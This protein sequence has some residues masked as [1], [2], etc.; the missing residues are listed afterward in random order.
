MN[1]SVIRSG[2]ALAAM[3]G[4][5]LA[6]CDSVKDV[7]EEP[8]TAIP[9]TTAVLQGTITGLGSARPVALS[10][11]GQPNC[12]AADPVDASVRVP[13]QCR[14]YGVA[15][16][17]QVSF[18]FGSL[19]VGTPY[20]ISVQAQP[21][22]KVCQV[23]NASGTVGSG[24]APSVVCEDSDAVARHD[25]TVNI[26]PALQTLPNLKVRVTTEEDI[27]EADAT[28]LASVSFPDVLIDTGISLPQFA[29]KVAATT[30]TTVNGETITNYCTFQQTDEFSLGGQNIN[31]MWT[32]GNP[33]V[34]SDATVVPTGPVV[35][36]VN[37]C[38]FTVT[39]T[40]QYHGTPA[41]TM[42]AG[43]MTLALRNHFTGLDE[44]TL[45]VTSFTATTPV[46]NPPTL[47]FPTPL[48]ANAQSIHELVVTRQPE[49]MHCV[50][51]GSAHVAADTTSATA[52]V[53]NAIIAPTGSAVLL[54]DPSVSEWW[55]YSDRQVRCHA[56][57]SPENSLVGTYQ[58]DVREGMQDTDPPRAYGR[59]REFLTFFADGTFLYGINANTASTQADTPNSTFPA[60]AAIRNNWA[61]A[62]GVTHGFYG[63]DPVA[64][65]VT[66][67]VFTNTA[68]NP[69]G[70]GIAGMP[71]YGTANTWTT[72]AERAGGF[73]WIQTLVTGT[74]TASQVARATNPDGLGTISLTFS[75][76]V[77]GVPATRLWTMSEPEAIDGELT[78]VW[79]TEDHRR[80][81]NYDGSRTFAFHMGV[82]G[83]GNLQDVCM[84]PTD[85]STQS[86]G[87]M[88][89]HAGSAVNDDFVYTCTPG[90]INPGARFVF[91]RTPDLPHYAPKNTTPSGLGIGPTI[92]RIAPGFRGRFPGTASQL[93][94]RP[95]SPVQFTVTQGAP[96]TLTVQDT[97]N[98]VP[99]AQPVVFVRQRAE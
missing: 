22:G 29:F 35:A 58:M 84:L 83:M 46:F 85:D 91:A 42:P 37:A 1:V 2:L 33:N 53:N 66:F 54:V 74:V 17:E 86:G 8:Y 6:G 95:T 87:V 98:G 89:K 30:D 13:A 15:G 67:T 20:E 18:S 99:I 56:I 14:F 47:A 40:V 39:T 81:F 78:G 88:T 90:I 4:A 28:G 9:P 68:T 26:L 97:L 52:N 92:P 72:D 12:L 77:G 75:G 80:M 60:S 70:R 7:R 21:Y 41:L 45:D 38:E 71:G 59:P 64:G 27:L 5:F 32:Q 51:A 49:G 10:Y 36:T 3:C 23:T 82:N 55:A 96:D 94:N 25:L 61:A 24:T 63:H 31:A 50:V 73:G 79:V 48:M 19:D 16:Q 65:T 11:N 93:D 62:S 43:G 57:P 69:A 34:R 76:N 44:Q